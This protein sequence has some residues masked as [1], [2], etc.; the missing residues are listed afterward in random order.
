MQDIG[1]CRQDSAPHLQEVLA[2]PKA[3]ILVRNILRRNITYQTMQKG[4]TKSK[5]R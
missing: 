5:S 1:G 3:K 2:Y 4:R